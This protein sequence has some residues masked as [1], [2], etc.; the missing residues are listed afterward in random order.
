MCAVGEEN[1]SLVSKC[2]DF[3][4]ALARQGKAFNFSLS[5][6]SNFSF[7]LDTRS[8]EMKKG[9][10]TK[11][12]SPSTLRRNAKRRQ[13]FLERKQNPSAVNHIV[14]SWQLSLLHLFATCV[15]TRQPLKRG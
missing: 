6:G 12:P 10:K 11:K 2:M 8:K 15:T 5:I 1:S 3:C 14:L 13:D 7:F 4:Q 9:I